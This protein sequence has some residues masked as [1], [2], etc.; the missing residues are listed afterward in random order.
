M[1]AEGRVGG[2]DHSLSFLLGDGKL[3]QVEGF[4][5][6]VAAETD[7]LEQLEAV[8]GVA[9]EGH[10]VVAG[11]EA[12]FLVQLEQ[13]AEEAHLDAHL[14]FHPRRIGQTHLEHTADAGIDEL[15]F[16]VDEITNLDVNTKLS[17]QIG[18]ELSER[19]PSVLTHRRAAVGADGI[20]AIVDE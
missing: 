5:E 4:V 7:V 6:A 13:T 19:I 18:I 10:A 3:G 2:E 14:A 20:V 12:E 9:Q 17:S 15:Y 16:F 11:G 1:A 8:E